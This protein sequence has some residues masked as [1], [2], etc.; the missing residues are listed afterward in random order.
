MIGQRKTSVQYIV[1]VA[2]FDT[3][4]LT[5]EQLVTDEMAPSIK[6]N[7]FKGV[8]QEMS[9]VYDDG[10]LAMLE[11]PAVRQGKHRSGLVYRVAGD[12]NPTSPCKQLVSTHENLITVVATS[13]SAE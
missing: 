5:I 9:L 13:P 4:N 8:G 2:L 6:K 11:V 12:V 10:A 7:V 1:T 3:N